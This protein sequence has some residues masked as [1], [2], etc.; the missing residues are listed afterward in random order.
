M[1]KRGLFDPYM[2]T[3]SL[4][5]PVHYGYEKVENDHD[6]LFSFFILYDF[7]IT[8]MGSK[9]ISRAWTINYNAQNYGDVI[10][11]PCPRLLQN[12]HHDEYFLGH[13]GP[14]H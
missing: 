13:Q 6:F 14:F 7:V 5:S 4:A 8:L 3:A 1:L 10:T 12:T 2:W 11:C 9:Q